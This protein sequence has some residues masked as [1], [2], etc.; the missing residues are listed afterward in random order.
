MDQEQIP[1][2]TEAQKRSAAATRTQ[3][4]LWMY[5]K[6]ERTKTGVQKAP[7]CRAALRRA[8]DGDVLDS[9]GRPTKRL[10][11]IVNKLIEC[12]ERGESWAI[13][14]V[15]DRLDGKVPQKLEG[16]LPGGDVTVIGQIL[17]QAVGSDTPVDIM[18]KYKEAAAADKAAE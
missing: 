17:M 3:K 2:L 8:L 6:A 16:D 7:H 13:K 5:R 12:A 1:E 15:F 18:H 9:K 11:V 4:P 14:E 10:M